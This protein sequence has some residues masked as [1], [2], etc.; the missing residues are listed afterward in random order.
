MLR[1]CLFNQKS[2]QAYGQA[3]LVI[4]CALKSK[5]NRNGQE[6]WSSGYVTWLMFERLWVWILSPHTGW[7]WHF[8]HWFVVKNCIVC[9]KRLK[10]SEKEAGLAN[11]FLSSIGLVL[12]LI[13]SRFIFRC[14]TSRA[15]LSRSSS[16]RST[17]GRSGSKRCRCCR[18]LCRPTWTCSRPRSRWPCTSSKTGSRVADSEW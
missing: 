14:P 3:D 4:T 6:P 5:F 10:T 7:A 11:F 12:K 2:L 18:A 15:S 9:L 13:T 17:R 1:S 16:H 8:S